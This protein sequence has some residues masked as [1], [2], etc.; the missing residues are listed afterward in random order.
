M[1]RTTLLPNEIL[2]MAAIRWLSEPNCH[3]FMS[4]N[5]MYSTSHSP[6]T[7][8]DT[9]LSFL[10]NPFLL[11]CTKNTKYTA[12]KDPFDTTHF[13]RLQLLSLLDSS[14][15]SICDNSSPAAIVFAV[16]I[17]RCRRVSVHTAK[18]SNYYRLFDLQIRSEARCI[19]RSFSP[20]A[21]EK[22]K[23]NAKKLRHLRVLSSTLD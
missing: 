13:L 22:Q 12:I 3:K 9:A 17:S 8:F 5:L 19:E 11:I 15:F 18:C 16:N 14:R 23:Q 20:V 21:R 7:S 6:S 10:E 4:A 1:R 2:A